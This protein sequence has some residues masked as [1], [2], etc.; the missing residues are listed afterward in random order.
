MMAWL[1]KKLPNSI[2]TQ[3]H[4]TY[5]LVVI[6]N[7]VSFLLK[8]SHTERTTKSATKN[9]QGELGVILTVRI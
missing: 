1:H 4:N 6:I 9:Q 8:D 2:P 7:N 3:L 5:K